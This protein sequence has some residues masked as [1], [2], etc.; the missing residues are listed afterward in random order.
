MK[1]QAAS[2]T[3][4]NGKIPASQ[5]ASDDATERLPLDGS[6]GQPKS[7]DEL[8]EE[9]P[10]VA[11]QA[12]PASEDIC[13]SERSSLGSG[14]RAGAYRIVRPTTCDVIDA[15]IAQKAEAAATKRVVIGTTRKSR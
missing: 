2:G 1:A 15:A 13:P 3:A 7:D 10:T 12:R 6:D 4:T 5:I 11:N 8:F 14:Q 9:V